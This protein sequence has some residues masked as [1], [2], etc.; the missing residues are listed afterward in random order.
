MLS[1]NFSNFSSHPFRTQS[2]GIAHLF[3]SKPAGIAHPFQSE[4]LS[5]PEVSSCKPQAKDRVMVFNRTPVLRR[6]AAAT[7]ASLSFFFIQPSLEARDLTEALRS[8]IPSLME[9]QNI[10]GVQVFVFRPGRTYAESFGLASSESG[11][12]LTNDTAFATGALRAPLSVYAYLRDRQARGLSLEQQIQTPAGAVSSD[13]LFLM[14]GGLQNTHEGLLSPGVEESVEKVR[15]ELLQETMEQALEPGQHYIYAPQGYEWIFHSSDLDP[16]QLVREQILEP[17]QL[18]NSFFY[19]DRENRK[20]ARGYEPRGKTPAPIDLPR[21]AFRS[22]LDLLTTA[23]DYGTFLQ[24]LAKEARGGDPV[25]RRILD[26][27]WH[28]SVPGGRSPGFYYHKLCG[29]DGPGFYRILSQYPGFV[30]GAIFTEDGRG[31]VVLLNA[32]QQITLQ[33]ILDRIISDL[34]PECREFLDQT[35][36]GY[37]PDNVTPAMLEELTG[38]YRPRY[39]LTGSAGVFRFLADTHLDLNEG[40]VRFS[41]F[42]ETEPS[43]HLIPLAPDLFMARGQ[44]GMDG[45]LVR[46]VRNQDGEVTGLQTDLM[47]YEKVNVL[48]SIGGIVG[49]SV[50]GLVMLAIGMVWF[51]VRRRES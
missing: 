33:K 7:L 49:F 47:P 26:Q 9:D 15:G 13:D 19:E 16:N 29:P 3:Q 32:R 11:E 22:Y 38:Y 30:S 43:I 24:R 18:K 17:M 51:F 35:R 12:K 5:I 27:R 37:Y 41:G 23:T 48:F 46:V 14:I 34:Y 28:T 39:L 40:K 21:V 31:A 1:H 20:L 36:A 25:A 42:F 2:A 50:L 44:A 8:Y 10:Q 6:I 4:Q 45:W